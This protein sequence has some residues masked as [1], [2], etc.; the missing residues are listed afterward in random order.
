MSKGKYFDVDEALGGEETEPKPARKRVSRASP[1]IRTVTGDKNRPANRL[2]DMQESAQ[3]EID[4]A[5]KV[6]LEAKQEV[7]KAKRETEFVQE[8]L[9][10]AEQALENMR[11]ELEDKVD[12]A[13]KGGAGDGGIKLPMPVT[14]QEV[15]FRAMYIDP[16]KIVVSSE[17]ERVQ[18]FLDEVSVKDILPSIRKKG[19]QVPGMVRP[20]GNGMYEL[21]FGSRRN[22]VAEI[23]GNDFFTLVGPVPDADVR[24]LSE[25]ENLRKDIS[26]YEKAKSYQ[27]LLDEGVYENWTQLGAAKGISSSHISRYSQLLQLDSSF[28]KILPSPSDMN[29]NYGETVL[30]LLAKAKEEVLVAVEELL[31][32][33]KDALEGVAEVLSYKEILKKLKAATR[34]N[35]KAPVLKKPVVYKSKSGDSAFK[36]SILT[37]GETKFQFENV[38]QSKIDKLLKVILKELKMS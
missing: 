26:P 32:L 16:S 18:D 11:S 3:R 13:L 5:K 20:I 28:I 29:L 19:Q 22:K 6:A 2:K 24:E 34:T 15:V 17:N 10:A 7:E 38:D 25:E 37:N 21:I 31:E 23:L 9:K 14:K 30:G 4:E 12:E 33:R 27:K 8:Q 36:H 35:I 1:A